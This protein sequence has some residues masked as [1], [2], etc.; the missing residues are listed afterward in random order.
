MAFDAN[1]G[2]SVMFGGRVGVSPTQQTF[3]FDGDEWT[4]LSPGTLPSARA[5]HSM[6][7][8]DSND[9][10]DAVILFGGLDGN[11]NALAETWKWDGTNWTQLSPATSPPA[12]YLSSM[13]YDPGRQVTVLYGGF[14]GTSQLGGNVWEWNGT[15]WTKII[16]A[17]GAPSNR[18]S[19]AMT[20]DTNI[21]TVLLFGGHDGTSYLQDTWS[22]DGT[23]WVDL[24]P[25]TTPRTSG[26]HAVVFDSANQYSILFG[27]VGDS[28][29]LNDTLAYNVAPSASPSPSA[30]ASPSPSMS[31]SPS[32]SPS[33]S[34]SPSPSESPSPS[35]EPSSSP[36]PVASPSEPPAITPPGVS[37]AAIS[38]DSR[39][40]EKK[41]VV[42]VLTVNG[43][44]S[45]GTSATV[46][47][48]EARTKEAKDFSDWQ[49]MTLLNDTNWE[50][51]LIV[52]VPLKNKKGKNQKSDT[53]II[54]I[55]ATDTN[56]EAASIESEFEMDLRNLKEE[57][58]PVPSQTA[59]EINI[60]PAVEVTKQ[61][62]V[63]ERPKSKGRYE[64]TVLIEGTVTDS[65]GNIKSLWAT[66]TGAKKSQKAKVE[67]DGSW[68]LKIKQIFK[69]K[70]LNFDSDGI[71][72]SFPTIGG[73]LT[74]VD[75]KGAETEESYSITVLENV[76]PT[77][78]F[79]DELK[80]MASFSEL[81]KVG[82]V[83]TVDVT[84]VAFA[85]VAKNL[86]GK[87]VPLLYS[88]SYKSLKVAK[89]KTEFMSADDFD[90]E[91]L[92][93]AF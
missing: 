14:D 65:D 83:E 16:P 52:S 36:S 24:S 87:P 59:P 62:I 28:D 64:T 22:W 69:T 32:P 60:P 10:N 90:G 89:G 80:V 45:P 35:V 61:T 34:M 4:Q 44:A 48:V 29:V 42:V 46:A 31:P 26:D 79:N 71:V 93:I 5:F 43:S 50:G 82:S 17:G 84:L 67:A 85:K 12:R 91:T 77:V 73:I 7:H 49:P 74:A 55:R 57:P 54:G 81:P 19:H 56:G 33:P 1:N 40:K 38:V 66:I 75:N 13:A 15:N 58:T 78:Q 63:S 27:G 39:E 88:V 70:D 2:V 23:D 9:A 72:R 30:S 53:T 11:P 37:L 18:S 86:K 25:A 51:K 47:K 92:S 68:S 76:V 8:H 41:K 6:A 3:T 20:Y 21:G